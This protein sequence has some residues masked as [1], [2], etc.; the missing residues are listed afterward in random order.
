MSIVT[1][2][3]LRL[4][5]ER[6]FFAGALA[7]LESA[8]AWLKNAATAGGEAP[9]W[10]ALPAACTAARRGGAGLVRRLAAA[11]RRDRA[12]LQRRLTALR[13]EFA[14]EGEPWVATAAARLAE[15]RDW[16]AAPGRAHLDPAHA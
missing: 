7:D 3:H 10:P 1:L 15:R 5:M 13:A 11:L 9:E 14:C 6:E 4:R 8:Q 16:D 2:E 12:Q